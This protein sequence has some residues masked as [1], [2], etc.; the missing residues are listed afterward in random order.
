M[1]TINVI[2]QIYKKTFLSHTTRQCFMQLNR[3]MKP[4][5]G[6]KSFGLSPLPFRLWRRRRRRPRKA[7]IKSRQECRIV[8]HFLLLLS[9]AGKRTFYWS[10]LWPGPLEC[11]K[12]DFVQKTREMKSQ[13]PSWRARCLMLFWKKKKMMMSRLCD[14]LPESASKGKTLE[15]HILARSSKKLR[16]RIFPHNNRRKG[17]PPPVLPPPLPSGR[18]CG[19]TALFNT[20]IFINFPPKRPF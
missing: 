11:F 5:V 12:R 19:E 16:R 10:K 2:P 18:V 9:A 20:P 8:I 14:S 15:V 4:G 17:F 6:Q 13:F 3:A 7:A 1:I